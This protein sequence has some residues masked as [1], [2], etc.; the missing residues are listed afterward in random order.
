MITISPF[1][2]E[3][4]QAVTE[5]ILNIQREEFGL[6]VNIDSQPD[7]LGINDFYQTDQGNFWLAFDDQELVGTIALKDIGQQQAALR[8]MFVKADHRGHEHQV[9]KR[10]L[11]TLIAW[12][13]TKNLREIYLG[14]TEKFLAAHRFYEKHGFQVVTK[15]RLPLN[16]SAMEID[17][18]FY[19]RLIDLT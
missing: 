3:H 12:C 10:L 9:G 2:I 17:T 4:T 11:E 8:K 15:S 19:R 18:K 7:L 5:L 6:E 1:S 13:E 14:T 16:F